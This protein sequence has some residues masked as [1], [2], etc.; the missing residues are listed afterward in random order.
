MASNKG[1]SSAVWLIVF[2]GL[3]FSVA[4]LFMAL[5]NDKKTVQV[6]KPVATA[7]VAVKTG[8]ANRV[9]RGDE[10][11]AESNA[12]VTMVTT[13]SKKQWKEELHEQI[14]KAMKEQR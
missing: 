14:A 11:Y 5:K 7:K 1:T 8:V 12:P 13:A 4:M 6:K 10:V 3:S 2:I 9:V